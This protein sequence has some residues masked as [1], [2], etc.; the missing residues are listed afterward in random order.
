MH[1]RQEASKTLSKAHKDYDK[2]DH[3]GTK[4]DKLGHFANATNAT[5]HAHDKRTADNTG[6]AEIIAYQKV[7]GRQEASK[8]LSK[9][10]EEYDK[11][12]HTG[13]KADKLGHF[14]DATNA[15]K[16]AHDKRTADNTGEAEMI[17]YQRVHGRQET[18]KVLSKAHE[19]YEKRDHHT[20]AKDMGHLEQSTAATRHAHDKHSADNTTEAE[21]IRYQRLHGR[22]ETSKF[23]SKAREEYNQR[24]HSGTKADELGNFAAATKSS[25]HHQDERTA[26]NTGEA[27]LVAYQRAHAREETSKHLAEER[28]AY[29]VRRESMEGGN[30]TR[31]DSDEYLDRLLQDTEATKASH[32]KA[33]KTVP[34]IEASILKK[35]RETMG[36]INDTAKNDWH[37]RMGKKNGS[38]VSPRVEPSSAQSEEGSEPSSQQNDAAEATGRKKKEATGI[39]KRTV[40]KKITSAPAVG[41]K[42]SQS[43]RTPPGREPAAKK[44][45]I[46]APKQRDGTKKKTGVST[47]GP[48]SSSSNKALSP[49]PSP[50]KS[51]SLGEKI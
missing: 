24:D 50:S 34:E 11:R 36:Q 1:G 30:H 12:D 16:H 39:E 31:A 7:H 15:T 48:K 3:S 18:S 23:L 47:G 21:M 10:H 9:A 17:A 14:A 42:G 19:E 46:D 22:E 2:R 33:F 40:K 43:R 37:A 5:K 32:E 8:T 45:S 27:E 38:V 25:T 28:E 6:E 29:D 41:S 13:T 51:A 44:S 35:D 4:A 49:P 20:V 26:D